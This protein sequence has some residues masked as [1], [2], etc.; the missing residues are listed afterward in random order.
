MPLKPWSEQEVVRNSSLDWE[1]ASVGSSMPI[2]SVRGRPKS[3][4]IANMPNSSVVGGAPFNQSIS[5]ERPDMRK[6]TQDITESSQ[7]KHMPSDDELIREIRHILSTTDL[8][9]ITK[10]K[11]RQQLSDFYGVNLS[12]KK[13]FIHATIDSILKGEL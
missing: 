9:T 8:M 2:D 10:K 6:R 1:L 13:Q 5:P 4:M 11:V 3:D 7:G 12:A